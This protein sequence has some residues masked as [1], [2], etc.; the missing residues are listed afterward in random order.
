MHEFHLPR[1]SRHGARELFRRMDE[2][3]HL[4]WRA[5][6]LAAERWTTPGQL[7][8]RA[9]T[10]DELDALATLLHDA[11]APAGL[12]DTPGRR[13]F[14]I[15]AAI[16]L[17]DPGRVPVTEG[18]RDDVWAWIAVVLCPGLVES[19]FSRVEERFQGGVRNTFQRLWMRGS[20]LREPLGGQER[21]VGMSEDAHVQ[22]FERPGLSASVRTAR[23]IAEQWLDRLD[24]GGSAG[25]EAVTRRA[26]V[27]LGV[28]NQIV[29]L[30][31]LDDAALRAEIARQ[32]DLAAARTDA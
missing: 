21:L 26:M 25:L 10:D 14:D 16:L 7:G 4:D 24:A 28:T 2:I 11:A 1:L 15:Q 31:A 12:G 23:L 5:R 13:R 6:R 20:A 30:D 9:A 27:A 17:S 8:A 3:V 22:V 18:L 29:A 32:F 19:R